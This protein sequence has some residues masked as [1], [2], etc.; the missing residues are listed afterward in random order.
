VELKPLR[1]H[2]LSRQDHCSA[3]NQGADEYRCG[4]LMVT[5]TRPDPVCILHD[6]ALCCAKNGLNPLSPNRNDKLRVQMIQA[7]P[8]LIAAQRELLC[9]HP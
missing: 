3:K 8:K 5:M 1:L 2:Q 6:Y 9:V 4:N 7:E